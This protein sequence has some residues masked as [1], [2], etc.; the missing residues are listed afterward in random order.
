MK[1][2]NIPEDL[3]NLICDFA[4][5]KTIREV[6]YCL[7]IVLVIKSHRLPANFYHCV[8]WS[9]IESKFVPLPLVEF[10]PIPEFGEYFNLARIQQ[11]LFELDFRKRRVRTCG[12]RAIWIQNMN[13]HW[14]FVVQ[15]GLFLKILKKGGQ[16][17]WCPT[18]RAE[19]KSAGSRFWDA[20]YPYSLLN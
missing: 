10:S 8:V 1:I 3:Q 9:W 12:N 15:F 4:W 6:Q 14:S 17:P 13:D 19:I 16:N 2:T 20:K 18:Y 7:D 5:K 11:I